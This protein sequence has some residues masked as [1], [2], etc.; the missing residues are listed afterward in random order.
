MLVTS[1]L[2]ASTVKVVGEPLSVEDNR[3]SLAL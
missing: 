1:R 3:S 2:L